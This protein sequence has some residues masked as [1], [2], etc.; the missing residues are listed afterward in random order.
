MQKTTFAHFKSSRLSLAWVIIAVYCFIA[1]LPLPTAIKVG[2]DPSWQYA[3]SRAAADGLIF[4]RDIIF[5]VGPFGYLINGAPLEEN[6]FFIT[7]FRVVV[8]LAL[9]II[10]IIKIVRLETNIQKLSFSLSLFIAYWIGM[11]SSYQNYFN[12]TD[13]QILFIFLIILSFDS[14]LKKSLRWW[15]LGLGAFAGF[16]LLT[17]F[18]LGISTLGSLILFL[19]ACLYKGIKSKLGVINSIFAI[20][21][22]LLAAISV[23][24]VLLAPAYSLTN[25][26]KV[27]ISLAVSGTAAAFTWLI[28]QR[29]N[30]RNNYQPE[31]KAIN[32]NRLSNLPVK[33]VPWIVLYLVYCFCLFTIIANSF[34][35][36]TDY[37][38]TSLEVSSGYSSAM[39][40]VASPKEL[41]LA[42]SVLVVISILIIMIAIQDS[43]ELSVAL[44]FTL[45][46][47]FK[48]GFV[49]QDIHILLFAA[50]TPIISAICLSKSRIFR[51]QK[52]ACLINLYVLLI[53][54][55]FLQIKMGGLINS[56]V[57]P[58]IV[59]SNLSYLSD[60]NSL[61]SSVKAKSA[62]N[63]SKVKLPEDVLIFVKDKTI[64]IIPWEL[65]LVEANKLNWK[66]TP[67]LQS[68]A[69]Y[70]TALD[71]INLESFLKEPREY[72]FY[73]FSSI[74]RRHPFFDQPKTFFYVFC[75]YKLS[76]DIPEFIN[77]SSLKN[78][79]ILEKRK[80]SICSASTMGKS[81]SIP[82][83]T[84]QLIE[85][86]DR[87]ITRAKVKF[88]YSPFGK[89]YKTLFRSP[90][91]MMKVTYINGIRNSYRIIPDNSDNGV[92]VSHLPKDD[93]E[94][95]SFFRGQLPAQVKS[96]SFSTSNSLLYAP[97]IEMTFSS[98]KLL[99]PSIKQRP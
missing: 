69:A 73:N 37:L 53:A 70:T 48:H 2:L 19:S 56:R 46:L 30:H 13:Y 12:F 98:Y 94:A 45:A 72:I 11:S 24:F 80:S 63:L 10:A 78:L 79:M 29:I 1:F 88:N 7:V 20:I 50:C 9:F 84:S 41:G 31:G 23:S 68:Y 33:L 47:A 57:D 5:T 36:W 60:F 21:N 43:I 90:P 17:K 85:A 28:Q 92:I 74:D 3:I 67:N 81:S 91:V 65:S 87:L 8:H 34:P 75:N 77:T 44:L 27:L 18:T 61:Q 16:C 4:G 95:M 99:E 58:R 52:I 6:L 38:K 26:S 55:I 64:D 51:F 97:N 76:S 15:S 54:L 39:S 32:N 35:S 49:R 89:I 66:P 22:S 42:I 62:A 82:W 86:S 71:N 25:L 96:F 59:V 40:I 14:F 83:N 93:S